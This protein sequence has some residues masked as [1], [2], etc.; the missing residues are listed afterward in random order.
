MEQSYLEQI[1]ER[2]DKATPGAWGGI[3]C[4]SSGIELFSA[5]SGKKCLNTMKDLEF[6]TNARKDVP[7]L[8][9]YIEQ[10]QEALELCEIFIGLKGEQ[11]FSS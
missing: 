6:I 3:V 7:V 11:V 4:T 10:L 8:L 9:D 5:V 1:R 2:C